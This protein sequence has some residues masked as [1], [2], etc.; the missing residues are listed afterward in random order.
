MFRERVRVSIPIFAECD[1]SIIYGVFDTL[2][3]AGREWDG[4]KGGGTPD[5]LFEPRLVGTGPGPIEL[6]TGVRV[7][8]QDTIDEATVT[9][10]VFVPN[11]LVSVKDGPAV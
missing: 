8:A 5:G 4:M 6:I 1:P 9:D 10:I 7:L 3:A 2:W 11:V